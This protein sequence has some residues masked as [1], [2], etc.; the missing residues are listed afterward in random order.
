MTDNAEGRHHAIFIVRLDADT[1]GR[2]TGIVERVLTGE[3]ARIDGLERVGQ[4]L[5]SMLSGGRLGK[6]PSESDTTAVEDQGG[7]DETR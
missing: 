6:A 4:L 5:S 2:I 3:K 7:H 1:S